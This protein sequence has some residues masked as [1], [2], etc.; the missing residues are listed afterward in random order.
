[1]T[2][3]KPPK[4][5]L[6]PEPFDQLLD[7]L[8][9]IITVTYSLMVLI[10]I[11]VL[12]EQVPQ[13]FNLSGEVTAT[14]SRYLLLILPLFGSLTFIMLYFLNKAPHTFNYTVT[15]TEE[16]AEHEY[17]KATRMIRWINLI[18]ALIFGFVSFSVI[19][20]GLGFTTGLNSFVMYFLMVSLFG[21]IGYYLIY[22]RIHKNRH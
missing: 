9:L 2:R 13:H 1:M 11:S 4:L 10:S 22:D 14:G 20:T 21:V 6:S 8:G 19:S 18:C 5:K 15:I 16:N 12:P 7:R 17:R 3:S